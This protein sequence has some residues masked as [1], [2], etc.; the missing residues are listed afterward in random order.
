MSVIRLV[1]L[2]DDVPLSGHSID[3]SLQVA[4][5]WYWWLCHDGTEWM[6]VVWLAL[7]RIWLSRVLLSRV[8]LVE[9][10]GEG[11]PK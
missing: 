10:E 9:M 2:C 4:E 8:W 11:E 5:V 6:Y 3:S 1:A 7:P